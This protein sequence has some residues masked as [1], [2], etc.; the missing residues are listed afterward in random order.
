MTVTIVSLAARG[1]GEISV[2]FEIRSGEHCQREQ[3]LITAA[4]CADLHLCV[5]ECGT[6]C[7]DAVSRGAELCSA[8]KRGLY[9]LGYGS[10]SERTLQRKLMM[11]GFSAEISAEAVRELCRRGY[12]DAESDAKREAERCVA[13][14]WGTRRIVATLYQKG[15]PQEAVKAAIHF[16]EDEGVDYVDLCAERI[17]R[18]EGSVPGDPDTRRR[19]TASLERNGFSFSEIRE[20][21]ARV[22]QEE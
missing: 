9:L 1:E 16:L 17:R 7:Y 20:A 21:F 14:L 10:C 2:S 3:F 22:A 15:Y 18:K 6:D 8:V 13:K 4:L 5:G 12:L 11:K 19:L